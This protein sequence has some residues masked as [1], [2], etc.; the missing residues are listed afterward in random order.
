MS[1]LTVICACLALW[2]ALVGSRSPLLFD[3]YLGASL[4]TFVVYAR[5]KRAAQR[6]RQRIPEKCLH[7]LE[8]AGGWP[9]AL[10][11]QRL[12]LHKSSKRSFQ[13]FFRGAAL[14][15]CLLV[16]ALARYGCLP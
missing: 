7:L 15:N 5:D 3:L 2:L 11:A 16:A 10:L 9:G 6:N 1:G 4:V 8:V 14:L 13:L 12:L